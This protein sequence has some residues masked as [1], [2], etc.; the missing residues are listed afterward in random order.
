VLN[1]NLGR[2]KAGGLGN[3]VVFLNFEK[4]WGKIELQVSLDVGAKS[5]LL[6]SYL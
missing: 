2:W 3:L 5:E 4:M 6:I 1:E